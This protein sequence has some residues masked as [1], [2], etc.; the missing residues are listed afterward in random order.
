MA[1][2]LHV[3]VP[4]DNRVEAQRFL[5]IWVRA[6]EWDMSGIQVLNHVVAVQQTPIERALYLAKKQW[7]EVKNE[8]ETQLLP[9][10]SHFDPAAL[11]NEG[12]AGAAVEKVLQQQKLEREQQHAIIAELKFKIQTSKSDDPRVLRARLQTAENQLVNMGRT[13]SFFDQT[14][15]YIAK[16]DEGNKHECSI[17]LGDCSAADASVTRCGHI[18]CTEC[19]S[20]PAGVLA[21]GMTDCPICKQQISRKDVDPILLL[22]KS[23]SS[24]AGSADVDHNRYGSKIARIIAEL[25][26]IHGEDR[27]SRVLVF[28]QWNALLLKLEAALEHYGVHCVA[29]RGGVADRQRTI[30][31]FAEGTTR[32][33]LLMA[34]E[35]DDSG[36]NLTCSNHVFFVHPMAAEPEVIKACERQALGRVRRRG[37]CKDVHLYRFAAS[38]TIEEAHARHHHEILFPMEST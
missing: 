7:L 24:A 21:S 29:L 20:G 30:T 33:V 22:R 26:R 15:E 27:S 12:S 4:P 1:A 5:D 3:F 19:I 36:L 31:A 8:S 37:Q 34:M 2:L 32:Y 28:V 9:F 16:L 13:I 35:H 38:G 25:R 17:C 11:N 14:L 23:K 10:C 18:F 6:D